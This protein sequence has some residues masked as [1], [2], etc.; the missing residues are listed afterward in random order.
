MVFS[1]PMV[2]H[3]TALI[4][5]VFFK[6]E[7]AEKLVKWKLAKSSFCNETS[8]CVNDPIRECLF[9][10]RQF[11]GQTFFSALVDAF[12]HITSGRSRELP[13]VEKTF[14]NV[15]INKLGFLLRNF[16]FTLQYAEQK[17]EIKTISS[18]MVKIIIT[19]IRQTT[20]LKI[21]I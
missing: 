16:S 14:S 8:L 4:S 20:V 17:I 19:K 13:H 10:M 6:D 5:R 18:L 2:F 1:S 9:H 21:Q 7:N 15:A 3:C 12:P 11:S